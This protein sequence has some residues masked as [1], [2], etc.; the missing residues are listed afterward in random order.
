MAF[1]AFPDLFAPGNLGG[2][3]VG[4]PPKITASSLPID[5]NFPRFS[6]DGSAGGQPDTSLHLE[7]F[8]R[9]KLNN[10]L[11]VTPGVLVVFN[12]SHNAA[13]DTLVIGVVR[14]TFRF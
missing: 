9:A 4:Q 10:F 2:I 6:T 12:P 3:L 1:S 11:D 5:Y 14:A 8:Y 7:V 13:S